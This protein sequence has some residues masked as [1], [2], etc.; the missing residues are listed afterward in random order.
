[1]SKKGIYPISY[2]AYHE[3]Y[4]DNFAENKSAFTVTVI[5][6]CDLASFTPQ[7]SLD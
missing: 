3:A 2:R 4:P 7:A 5:D 1:M 6:P